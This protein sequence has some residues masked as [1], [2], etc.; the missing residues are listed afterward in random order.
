MEEALC[1]VISNSSVEHLHPNRKARV[2]SVPTKFG[3][4]VGL[5]GETV[6]DTAVLV[7]PSLLKGRLGCKVWS[8]LGLACATHWVVQIKLRSLAIAIVLTDR[9][10]INARRE[11]GQTEVI[12]VWVVLYKRECVWSECGQVVRHS[13]ASRHLGIVA[14]NPFGTVRG[15]P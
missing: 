13:E 10:G 9:L 12:G 2:P 11:K 4:Q 14:V 3:I 15:L 6:S 7:L 5:K 1:R 8:E